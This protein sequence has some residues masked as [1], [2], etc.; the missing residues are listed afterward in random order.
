MWPSGS[1][2]AV[3][4]GWPVTERTSPHFL[5]G[6]STDAVNI[7]SCCSSYGI[8]ISLIWVRAKKALNERK[9]GGL[10]THKGETQM[11]RHLRNTQRLVPTVEVPMDQLHISAGEVAERILATTAGGEKRSEDSRI[12]QDLQQMALVILRKIHVN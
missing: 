9:I 2:G 3:R 4:I 10:K 12:F 5:G 11:N 6:K 8:E 1:E 7:L